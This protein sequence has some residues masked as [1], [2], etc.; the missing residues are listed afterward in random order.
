MLLVGDKRTPFS[1]EDLRHKEVVSF[2]RIVRIGRVVRE[3]RLA[4]NKRR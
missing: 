3:T 1:L 4:M 2:A